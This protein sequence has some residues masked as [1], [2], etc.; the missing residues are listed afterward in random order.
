MCGFFSDVNTLS[1]A[2]FVMNILFPKVVVCRH[3]GRTAF[4]KDNQF[5]CEAK[6]YC[7]V[8]VHVEVVRGRCFFAPAQLLGFGCISWSVSV[9][10]P[11]QQYGLFIRFLCLA[12]KLPFGFA[13][14]N[15]LFPV[16][17][18]VSCSF[19]P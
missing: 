1:L 3:F 6:I 19:S 10:C 13:I 8:V 2:V 15:I 9:T 4:P 16:L 7:V 12:G 18:F 11:W 5:G 14:M 17:D